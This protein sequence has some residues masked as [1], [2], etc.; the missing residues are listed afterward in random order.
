MT[1]FTYCYWIRRSG[2]NVYEAGLALFKVLALE[3]YRFCIQ[4][5]IQGSGCQRNDEA[6][7]LNTSRRS[8]PA[9]AFTDQFSVSSWLW[10]Q[11]EPSKDSLWGLV[12]R[13]PGYRSRGPRF[14]SRSCQTFWEVM[15][16]ER[17]PLNLVRITEKL[18]QRD[19][20]SSGLENQRLTAVG[21]RYA[22]HQTPSNRKRRH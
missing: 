20:G 22:D 11:N 3:N 2:V 15:G 14:D 6:V 13:V 7:M 4:S 17:G 16:L 8:A 12:F 19:S 21:I 9:F 10:K 5:A 18:L 1:F